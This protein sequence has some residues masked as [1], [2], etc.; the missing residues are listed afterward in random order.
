[1]I[2]NS[3]GPL[4]RK[5]DDTTDKLPSVEKQI[6]EK[7]ILQM[8]THPSSAP[9][10]QPVPADCIGYHKIIT[11]PMDLRTIKEKIKSYGNM[12]EFLADVRLM[13]QN[14]STFNR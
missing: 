3:T 5:H 6:C 8:Y 12:S 10:H 7:L 2:N 9:F 4:K 14:C 1:E 11:R 13:F